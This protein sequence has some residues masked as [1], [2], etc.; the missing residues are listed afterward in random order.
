[1]AIEFGPVD[2]Y[3]I[4]LLGVLACRHDLDSLI[5]SYI[6]TTSCQTGLSISVS[7][8]DYPFSFLALFFFLRPIATESVSPSVKS[9][10]YIIHTRHDVTCDTETRSVQSISVYVFT[11]PLQCVRDNWHKNIKVGTK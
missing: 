3:A 4:Y 5:T 2:L 10:D 7:G 9:M 11:D 1:M 6:A 8:L